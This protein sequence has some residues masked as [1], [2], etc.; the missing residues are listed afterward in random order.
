MRPPYPFQRGLQHFN[1]VLFLPSTTTDGAGK[2]LG[3]AWTTG[4]GT[5]SHPTP[6]TAFDTQFKRTKYSQVVTTTNQELGPR[7][8]AT[9]DYQF[10]LGN[11]DNL[12]GWYMS[13]IFRIETWTAD[14]G[15]LFVGMTAAATAQCITDTVA[16]HT[17]GL[18]HDTTDGQ[19]VLSFVVRSTGA[20]AKT[21]LTAHSGAVAPVVNA[22]GILA[23]GVMLLWEM[24]NFPNS[25]NDIN[26]NYRLSKAD[27]TNNRFNKVIYGAAGGFA[28]STG[29]MMA[30]QV[31]MSNG[32]AD[33]TANHYEISVANIYATPNSGEQF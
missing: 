22:S 18:W 4:V 28:N 17:G 12:G 26:W 1:G 29:T 23:S 2:G 5:V 20:A 14:T 3:T 25:M 19:D 8:S 24:W 13:T 7:L 33:T 16:T 21:Q 10:W 32:T 11:G 31:Q 15:R 9:S 30:P 6:S 27:T